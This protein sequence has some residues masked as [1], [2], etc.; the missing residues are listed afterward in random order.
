VVDVPRADADQHRPRGA[1]AARN[2]GE[3]YRKTVVR[4]VMCPQ[5]YR[6]RT[7]DPTSSGAVI[8]PSTTPSTGPTGI[9]G[10]ALA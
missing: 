6:D 7:S 5:V 1:T 8:D 10:V 4:L 3:L 9:P 2:S